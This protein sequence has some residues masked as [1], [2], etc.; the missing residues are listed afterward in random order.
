VTSICV[1]GYNLSLTEGTGVATYARNL[2][3][4]LNQN[5][6]KVNVLY[7]HKRGLSRSPLFREIGFFDD[8]A[9]YRM[10]LGRL[11]DPLRF[12][13]IAVMRASARPVDLSGK[14]IVSQFDGRLPYFDK[15]LFSPHLFAIASHNFIRY[16]RF[17]RIKLPSNIEIAHWTYPLPLYASSKRNI[18]T[19]HDLVPLRLPFT[20]LD[21]KRRYHKLIQ[22]VVKRADKIVTVSENSYHDLVEFFPEAEKKAVQTYQFASIPAKL[23]SKPTDD[24]VADVQGCF[25]LE[26]QRYFL[27]VGAIEPKKNVGRLLQA[28]LASGSDMPLVIAGKR[29]WKSDEELKFLDPDLN[30]FFIQQGNTT[31][32]TSRVRFLD[33]VPFPMLVSLIRGARALVFPSLYEGFGLP[34]LEAMSLG[35]PVIT[36][37]TSSLPEIAGDAGV[38]VDPYS[39]DEIKK[40]IQILAE[41]DV[42]AAEL[43]AAGK[44]RASLFSAERYA[45]ALQSAYAR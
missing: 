42:R 31:R 1:D 19:I 14:V 26:Y 37:N 23:R 5:G 30:R 39:V 6:H 15:L 45:A 35:T 41:D 22:K 28:Y 29:A 12:A 4:T 13:S 20:T 43:S 17:L 8:Y 9:D 25:D 18:Y 27:F 24:V 33:Y 21:H 40:A 16:R 44:E 38:L 11:L 7:G 10:S 34:V 2:T 36:S 3:K 32:V